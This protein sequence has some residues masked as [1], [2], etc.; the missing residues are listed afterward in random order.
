MDGARSA[1]D[2]W[3]SP[4]APDHTGDIGCYGEADSVTYRSI[5]PGS[6]L[7]NRGYG[8]KIRGQQIRTRGKATAIISQA[9]R[10]V[11]CGKTCHSA[12]VI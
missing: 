3:Y 11:A 6:C 12:H 2:S 4:E 1:L 10:Q 8:G 5:A 7:N 9:N